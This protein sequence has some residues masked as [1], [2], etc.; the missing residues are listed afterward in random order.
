[1][2]RWISDSDFCQKEAGDVMVTERGKERGCLGC[3]DGRRWDTEPWQTAPRPKVS[4]LEWPCGLHGL[5]ASLCLNQEQGEWRNGS[6]APSPLLA[7]SAHPSRG[8]LDWVWCLFPLLPP[9][10]PAF[11]GPV[12][13]PPWETT[14]SPAGASQLAMATAGQLGGPRP[15]QQ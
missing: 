12:R 2:V 5:I 1:M 15:W 4:L 10:Y 14:R 8:V 13:K 11:V 6:Q 3:L 9:V 7:P